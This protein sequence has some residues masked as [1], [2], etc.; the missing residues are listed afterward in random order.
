MTQPKR[1]RLLKEYPGSP[2]MPCEA[3]DTSHESKDG[4]RWMTFVRSSGTGSVERE[5]VIN[6]PEYWEEVK[7]FN[8]E[9][10]SNQAYQEPKNPCDAH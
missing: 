1:Y 2:K 4:V 6:N 10:H 8:W 9:N 5:F 7:D 3:I